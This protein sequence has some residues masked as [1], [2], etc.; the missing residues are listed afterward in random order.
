LVKGVDIPD[1][2]SPRVFDNY[3]FFKEQLRNS[4]L[5]L[6]TVYR[7]LGKLIVVDISLDRNHDNPQL[8][9]ESLNSTGLDLSQ[10]DL[11]RN[12]VLMGLSSEEQETIY[13][14]YWYRMEQSFGFESYS[15]YFDR[16]MR[17][18]L[19]VKSRSGTIPKIGEVYSAFK[20]YLHTL[21]DESI[22]D[23]VADVYKYSRYFVSLA[24]L[25]E[26]DPELKQIFR[27]INMLRV[28]VAYPLLLELYDDYS[29]LRLSRQ[30]FIAI[31]RLVESYVFRRLICGIPT[32]TLNKTFAT[33]TRDI[34]KDNY[35]E[36][37]QAAFLLKDS[38][39]RFPKDDEF[40]YEFTMKDVYNLR[41]R[42]HLLD[43]LEN[44]DRKE[45][46]EVDGY[47]IEHV[48]PQNENLSAQWKKELGDEWERVHAEY[49]HTI[50][51][52]TLTGYNSEL[53]DHP[54]KEKREMPGGFKDSPIRLNHSLAKLEYWNE[55]QINQRAIKLADLALKI[56]KAPTLPPEVLNKYKGT[57]PEERTGYTME[58]HKKYLQGTVMEI[59]Q[60]L[61]TRILNLDPS[62]IE[63]FNKLYIAYKSST[64]FVDVVPQQSGLKLTL[65]VEFA[66]ID[67]PH[68]LARD[69]TGL[70][71]WG[72]GDVEVRLTSLEQLEEV[73]PL[74]RQSFELNR[75]D[76]V[77]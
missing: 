48:M 39:R 44:Y 68:S 65:N 38:Y 33:F 64:N 12:Y 13:N 49:L 24:F 74:I 66:E 6:N 7:G 20:N 63:Q 17:D 57:D 31:L 62:V 25:Q 69:V 71:R 11:I 10:A 28:D 23:I 72:N 19:T 30:D 32:N 21:Q 73:M 50:G 46:V 8:I 4:G 54:F 60:Q 3:R 53:S 9:F 1:S 34:D 43:K 58:D 26:E 37:V 36:S 56:W 29:A 40:W 55:E 15:T 75:E 76:D 14:R 16:F 5:D 35:L 18:Y 70:G 42:S 41:L 61:R 59:F 2:V 27:E 52:L 45:R 47:T 51:N 67:D 77:G 22:E